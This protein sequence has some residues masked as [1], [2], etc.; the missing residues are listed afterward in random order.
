MPAWFVLPLIQAAVS[1]ASQFAQNR[2][3]RNEAERAYDRDRLS[4]DT[5]YQRELELMKYQ[6]S[7]N[8][9][10][11]QMQRFKDAGLNPNLIYGQGTPGNMQAPRVPQ[12][13]PARVPQISMPNPMTDFMQARLMQAQTDLIETKTDESGIKQDLMKVQ[14]Q[15]AEAN[16]YLAPGYLDALVSQ[17]KS[18]AAIKQ[19]ESFFKTE[20]T[21]VQGGRD[22]G[23]PMGIATMQKQFALLEQKFDLGGKDAKIKAQIIQSKAFQNEL[24]RIQT[25]WMKDAEITPQHIYQFIMMFLQSLMR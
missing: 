2:A 19:Q 17:M 14:Q 1:A 6:N 18:N 10:A 25:E 13:G 16:P 7:F 23:V 22:T 3:N 9:P 20:M 11:A 4:T 5:A 15:V 21:Q 8:S 12:Q 24:S